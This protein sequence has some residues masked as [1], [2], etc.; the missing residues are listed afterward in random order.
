MPAGGRRKLA[1]TY[2]SPSGRLRVVVDEHRTSA[3]GT[4]GCAH[5]FLTTYLTSGRAN[6]WW[7]RSVGNGSQRGV[8]AAGEPENATSTK[9]H[10]TALLAFDLFFA[11]VFTTTVVKSN[12]YHRWYHL[13]RI[14]L[15]GRPFFSVGN[16]VGWASVWRRHT[17]TQIPVNASR[18]VNTSAF[19]ILLLDI[20]Y[21]SFSIS[22][23]R[24]PRASDNLVL[25]LWGTS[26][27]RR[28]GIRLVV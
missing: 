26:I 22:A 13:V 28:S 4:V 23:S 10:S 6:G 27:L 20:V 11:R 24:N 17:N 19:G 5:T 21:H 25:S 18:R 8:S 14:V 15:A 12:T 1:Q 3:D 7:C 16:L 2:G 9:L